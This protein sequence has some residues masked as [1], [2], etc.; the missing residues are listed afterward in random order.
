MIRK[1]NLM[2]RLTLACTLI[3]ALT[4]SA[5]SGGAPSQQTPS[6]FEKVT[7]PGGSYT[8]VTPGQL[9]AMLQKKDFFFVN[10]HI[11]YE[12]EIANTDAF[13]EYDQIGQK[14]DKLPADKNAKI[15]LYCRSGSMS[16]TAARTLVKAGYTNVW[17]LKG[18]FT[19]W[20]RQGFSLL[21]KK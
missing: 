8:N 18:G 6:E 21:K 5:C 10:V 19:D 15:V 7:V 12:G 14:L 1:M 16:D 20:E 17:N 3:L 11:P 9:N 2:A 13:L 4:M